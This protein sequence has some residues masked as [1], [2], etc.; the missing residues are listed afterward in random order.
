MP[1]SRLKGETLRPAFGFNYFDPF[2]RLLHDADD[3]TVEEDFKAL[4]THG[5][6]FIRFAACGYWPSEMKLYVDDAEAY[7]KRLD[8]IFALAEKYEI[9]LIPSLFW[10]RPTV[11]DLVGEP[12]DQWGNKE[13]KTHAFMRQYTSQVVRRYHTSPAL[14]GWELGNEYNLDKDLPA[15]P[16]TLPP[17]VPTLGTPTARSERDRLSHEGL[18]VALREFARAVREIDTIHFVTTGNAVPRASAWH[19]RNENSW[20]TDA[21]D[22]FAQM[23]LD[24]NPPPFAISVHL[25]KEDLQKIKSIGRI[26]REANR[27]LFIGEFQIEQSQDQQGFNTTLQSMIDAEATLAA[28]W[29]Y[30][31]SSQRDTFSVTPQNDRAYQLNA[32][33]ELNQANP[34]SS[35]ER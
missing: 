32:I 23:L 27:A 8:R 29:V 11:P 19:L 25:Y 15:D 24:E 22:Q 9:G 4:H 13:S 18:L 30:N 17:I 21:P 5:V 20:T 3:A 14:W 33:R 7:L 35:I 31:L 28:I 6:P 2:L 1:I 16:S 10:Y 12:C 26:A 34:A